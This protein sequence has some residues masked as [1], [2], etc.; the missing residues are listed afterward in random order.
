MEMLQI[1]CGITP[2]VQANK[3]G[4][5]RNH[6]YKLSKTAKEDY[7]STDNPDSYHTNKLLESL[8]ECAYYKGNEKT[9]KVY[10]YYFSGEVKQNENTG[11]VDE[12]I[13]T[14]IDNSANYDSVNNENTENLKKSDI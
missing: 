7:T 8:S 6:F 11:L 4:N 1:K 5:D 12:V 14:C 10:H 13:F 2:I 3:K 9:Y